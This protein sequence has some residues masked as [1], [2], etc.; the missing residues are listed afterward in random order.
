MATPNDPRYFRDGTPRDAA[1]SQGALAGTSIA[2]S[3]PPTAASAAKADNLQRPSTAPRTAAPTQGRVELPFNPATPT[4]KT[5]AQLADIAARQAKTAVSADEQLRR[6][7]VA[8]RAGT[9]P[10]PDGA[11][12]YAVTSAGTRVINTDGT[13]RS[14]AP[15]GGN[16]GVA[17]TGYASAAGASPSAPGTV[18]WAPTPPPTGTPASG[19]T[20]MGATTVA[21]GTGALPRRSALEEFQSIRE[22]VAAPRMYDSTNARLTGRADAFAI[23]DPR[24]RERELIRLATQVANDPSLKGFAGARNAIIGQIMGQ[25][26]AGNAASLEAIQQQGRAGLGMQGFDQDGALQEFGRR[27][28]R[29]R[30]RFLQEGNERLARIN[31]DADMLQTALQGEYQLEAA[32]LRGRNAGT[33]A[34]KEDNKRADDAYA[35]A[36]EQ[37][38]DDPIAA[39]VAADTA[40]SGLGIDQEGIYSGNAAA[41]AVRRGALDQTN[42]P[43][44]FGIGNAIDNWLVGNDGRNTLP[45]DFD[46]SSDNL[47]INQDDSFLMDVMQFGMPK[48]LEPYSL[49]VTDPATGEPVTRVVRPSLFGGGVPNVRQV[50]AMQR[51]RDIALRRRPQADESNEDFY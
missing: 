15:I 30:D 20:P 6:R 24:S 42:N 46:F 27:G 25:L 13:L 10:T 36:Q 7:D 19:T 11:S 12:G 8:M 18:D 17:P 33:A 5:N 32:G 31:N 14:G 34:R 38:P 45:E 16:F 21:S 22:G 1:A 39:A 3:A 49:T 43:Y 2:T 4:G 23:T 48:S 51:N 35:D 28:E 40:I 37:F 50:Q 44:L 29:L 47:G 9:A 41:N 26:D